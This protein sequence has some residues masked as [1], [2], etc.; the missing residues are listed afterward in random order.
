VYEYANGEN[1]ARGEERR[2]TLAIRTN[3]ILFRQFGVQYELIR[4]SGVQ[5]P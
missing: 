5:R 1:E 4:E 3:T 2:L